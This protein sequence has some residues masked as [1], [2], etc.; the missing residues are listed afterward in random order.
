MSLD[1]GLSERGCDADL[2]HI[3]NYENQ[4]LLFSR[5]DAGDYF[6]DVRA[7]HQIY[8]QAKDTI[9]VGFYSSVVYSNYR[10][11]SRPAGYFNGG[12]IGDHF[13]L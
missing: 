13:Q 12:R 10:V 1:R 5:S 8:F 3:D 7:L 2:R 11:D 4:V 9:T 6:H